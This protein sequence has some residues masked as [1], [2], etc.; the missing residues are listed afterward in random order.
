MGYLK[1]SGIKLVNELMTIKK[2]EKQPL[3]PLYEAVTNAWESIIDK[4]NIERLNRGNIEIKLFYQDNLLTE[5]DNTSLNFVAIEVCDN[6]IGLD[7]QN[8]ERITMLRDSSKG[9][10]NLGTGR[11]QYIHYFGETIMRSI[12]EEGGDY[13]SRNITL[14]KA[15][16]FLNHNAIIRED[17]PFNEFEHKSGTTVRM[18]GLLDEKDGAYYSN[19]TL[20]DLKEAIINHYLLKFCD[21]RNRFPNICIQKYINN[22]HQESED[23]RISTEDLPNVDKDLPVEIKYSQIDEHNKVVFTEH[24]EQF[25][26]VTF[27]LKKEKLSKNGLHLVSKGEQG[28]SLNIENLK[29]TEEI[30]G[31][32]YL[33]LLSGD[34]LDQ[35]DSDERGNIKLCTHKEFKE[36]EEGS[37]FPEEIILKENIEEETNKVISN[38]YSEF[39][40]MAQATQ[41]NVDE[42]R[43]TFL[44]SD[45]SIEKIR[46]KIKNTDSDEDI[47]QRIY[48]L[49]SEKKAEMDIVLRKQVHEISILNPTEEDYDEKLQELVDELTSAVPEQNKIAL[50]QYVAHRKLVLDAFGFIL[51]KELENHK[52]TGHINE[53]VFH[54]IICRQRSSIENVADS[55]LWLINEDFLYFKGTSDISLGKIMYH[56]VNIMKDV[57]T[58]EEEAY[59]RKCNTNEY[60]RR[61]D[62]LLFPEEGKAVIIEFKAP[63]VNVSEHLSQIQMYARLLHILSKD[64][65]RINTFWGYLIGENIDY[66]ALVDHDPLYQKAYKFGYYFK[67][68]SPIKNLQHQEAGSLYTEVISYSSL[69]ERAKIRNNIFIEKLTGQ[70]FVG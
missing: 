53:S 34:Y 19:L 54:N 51:A 31:C 13:F 37:L 33:F 48:E 20:A 52:R 11:V 26:L 35:R 23:L 67:P 49:D 10:Q 59:Q 30:A 50:S 41:M 7:S 16:S 1:S 62:V 60:N 25:R 66:E 56:G 6:G 58:P 40:E 3:Q 2:R 68:Y 38:A 28:T 65:F 42:L 36:Q 61:P 55:D 17:D 63:D 21:S 8:Y 39:S 29:P 15:D 46:K 9:H 69:L 4:F 43:K 47:L 24:S 70:H 27:K 22:V 44:L 64:E 18:V 5:I 14:S 12:Y 45:K 32:R 57:L